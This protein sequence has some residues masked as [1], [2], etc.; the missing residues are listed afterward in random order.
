LASGLVLL[1]FWAW[2]LGNLISWSYGSEE[3]L[4]LSRWEET[5]LGKKL[6]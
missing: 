4:F 3:A 6:Q 1:E 2:G 5:V